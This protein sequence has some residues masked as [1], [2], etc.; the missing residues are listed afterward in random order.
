M[1]S[2]AATVSGMRPV[3]GTDPTAGDRDVEITLEREGCEDVEVSMMFDGAKE[4][5]DPTIAFEFTTYEDQDKLHRFRV[6]DVIKV[7]VVI[8]T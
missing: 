5:L 1:S 3:E 7:R 2:G 6:G 4:T 8:N